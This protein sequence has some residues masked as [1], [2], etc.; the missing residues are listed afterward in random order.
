MIKNRFGIEPVIKPGRR[1]QFEVIA[2]G[3]KLAER[4]GNWFTRSFGGG[5]PNLDLIIERLVRK[6]QEG[7]ASD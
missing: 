1:G 4:G 6:R 2:D 3:E 7:S 5:Y